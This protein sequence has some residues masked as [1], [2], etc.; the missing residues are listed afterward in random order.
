MDNIKLN[1]ILEKKKFD[2][3]PTYD[4]LDEAMENINK[5]LPSVNR[6]YLMRLFKGYHNT[7]L[8][9]L[10]KILEKNNV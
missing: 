4:S 1:K 5:S 9:E 3:F 8:N 7:L 2:L 10:Q 6:F